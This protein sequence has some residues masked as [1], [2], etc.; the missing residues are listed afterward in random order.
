MLW[1]FN[2]W[3]FITKVGTLNFKGVWKHAW[4]KIGKFSFKNM[5]CIVWSWEFY[6]GVGA[7]V[8]IFASIGRFVMLRKWIWANELELGLICWWGMEC[9]GRSFARVAHNL[10][11][12]V[13]NF[14]IASKLFRNS[15]FINMQCW[16]VSIFSPKRKRVSESIWQ[17]FMKTYFHMENKD[18]NDDD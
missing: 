7:R 2:W 17:A 14:P 12:M 4:T 11:N 3:V 15:M 6:E 9:V 5:F 10:Q 18:N 16:K 1:S 13:G 8:L